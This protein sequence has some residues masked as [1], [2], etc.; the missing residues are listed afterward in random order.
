MDPDHTPLG[1]LYQRDKTIFAYA[2]FWPSHFPSG[3]FHSSLF[4]T[5]VF[6]VKINDRAVPSCRHTLDLNQRAASP[7]F[8]FPYRLE[9]PAF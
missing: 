8:L 5:A 2:H 6:T 9:K 4:H 3:H 7:I 1:I